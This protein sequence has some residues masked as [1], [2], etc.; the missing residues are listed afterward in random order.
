MS[1]GIGFGSFTHTEDMICFALFIQC[2]GRSCSKNFQLFTKIIL[3]YVV[4][5]VLISIQWFDTSQFMLLLWSLPAPRLIW[6]PNNARNYLDGDFELQDGSVIIPKTGIYFV[7]TQ[8][9]K[10]RSGESSLHYLYADGGWLATSKEITSGRSFSSSSGF[11]TLHAGQHLTVRLAA[12]STPA[13]GLRTKN[14]HYNAIRESSIT[15]FSV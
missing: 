15:I 12:A 3:P 14:S 4:S 2:F 5:K 1:H 10:S 11:Y 6:N 9:W 8:L 13:G 7:N